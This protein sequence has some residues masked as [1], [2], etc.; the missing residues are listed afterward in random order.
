MLQLLAKEKLLD[1]T[2]LGIDAT[3]LEANAALRSIVAGFNLGLVMRRLFGV[4]TARGLQ[5]LCGRVLVFLG[6]SGPCCGALCR[7]GGLAR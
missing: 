1:G 5:G 2:T 6:S 4:G 3:T 7:R